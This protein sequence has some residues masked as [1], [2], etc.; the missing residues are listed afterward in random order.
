M[1]LRQRQRDKDQPELIE[2]ITP[3]TNTAIIT[4]AENLFAA[5]AY[6]ETFSLEIAATHTGRW[7]LARSGGP[8]MRQHL[9]A[10]LAAAYPQADL[11]HLDLTRSPGLDPAW[12]RDGEQMQVCTLVLRAPTYLPLRTFRDVEIGAAYGAQADPMVG[13]LAALGNLP[14]GWRGLIQLIL[15]PA[16]D[17]W[18]Q[19]Y[20]RL[21]VEHP[22]VPERERVSSHADTSL[23]EVVALAFLLVMGTLALQ[24]YRWY[25]AGDVLHLAELVAAGLMGTVAVLWLLSRRGRKPIYDMRLVQEKMSGMAYHAQI[26]LAIFAPED[27]PRRQVE[28]RL[29][30]LAAGYRQFNLAVGNG[31]VAR[32]LN[33]HHDL[34]QLRFLPPRRRVPIL[35]TRELAGVWHLPQAQADVPLLDRT[36]ARRRLPLPAAV[37]FGCRIGVSGHQ[38]RSVPVAIPEEVLRRHLLLVAKTRRG[39]SSLLLRLAQHIMEVHTM[40]GVHPTLVLIDPHRDLA[41]AALGVVPP[42]RRDDVVYLD[43]AAHDRPFGLNLL[44]VR[45]GWDQ[46]KAVANLLAIFRHEFSGFWG[47]RMED[48]FRFALL[49][50]YAANQTL[51]K[52]VG[53][54]ERQYTI[55]DVPALL[56]DAPFRKSVLTHVTDPVVTSWWSGYYERLD[57]RFQMEVANP[58]ESKIHRFA[59]SAAARCI[60]GQP[61]STI[62]PLTWLRSGSIVIVNTAKGTVGED[63]SALLGATLLNLISLAVAEQACLPPHRRRPV[64]VVVDEFHTMPGADY[65]GIL[66][67]LAKYGTNL[68]L[69]TQSLARLAALD[70]EHPG[71]FRSL[72]FANLDGL[73]AFHTSAE[74]ARYLVPELGGE[75]DEQD[76][77]GLGEHQCYVKLSAA[78]ER[79]PTFSVQLDPPPKIES[80]VIEQLARTSAARYGQ[81]RSAVERDLRSALARIEASH[82]AAFGEQDRGKTRQGKSNESSTPKERPPRNEHRK[83][84]PDAKAYPRTLAGLAGGEETD[85]AEEERE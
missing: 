20:L 24:A 67:E 64:T 79:L 29:Q 47:P 19:N 34:R 1:K 2:I 48:A 72:V 84:K 82:P 32:S 38:S 69:A 45:L 51:C 63:T 17:D 10:Q 25:R 31:L 11:K 68:I 6:P 52:E 26:R 66:T 58:V 16:A 76:L 44:D 71:A 35:S 13:L 70:R 22:L 8:A 78:G 62:E 43:V 77:V 46:D 5:I 42:D 75:V 12:Q 56:A 65:E 50:L 33:P 55:L 7:F 53:G 9:E 4:P 59:G 3:R 54:R 40:D 21:T 39:K 28:E 41:Q 73:F 15:R 18:C 37:A 23:R 85:R 60:V 57:R 83:G 27:V 36:T 81:E 80:S 30:R 74:D 49:T 14:D 61:R